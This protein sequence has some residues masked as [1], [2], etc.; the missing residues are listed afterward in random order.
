MNNKAYGISEEL[1]IRCEK[2]EKELS[3]IL[4][5]FLIKRE[6]PSFVIDGASELIQKEVNTAF[7]KPFN[8]WRKA[9]NQ[10]KAKDL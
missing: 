6:L 2:A 5:N 8:E 3:V 10:K 1:F 7:F 4:K 9:K